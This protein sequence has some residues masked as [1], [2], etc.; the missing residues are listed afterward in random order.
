MCYF[1]V[2][3]QL[4][5]LVTASYIDTATE[6]DIC[7]HCY[8]MTVYDGGGKR[9]KSLNCQMQVLNLNI[10]TLYSTDVLYI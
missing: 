5:S 7:I 8:E 6:I 9:G 3:Y 4:L 2:S 10:A 1:Q